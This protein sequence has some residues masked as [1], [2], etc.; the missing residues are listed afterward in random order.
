M[1]N[2]PTDTQAQPA[3]GMRD[4]L[5]IPNFSRLWTGQV[6][7]NFG[8]SLTN[9]TLLILVNELTGSTAAIALMAIVLGIP[10]VIF[11]TLAGVYVDRLN[12]QKNYGL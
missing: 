1:T 8:D 11:G 4:V 5:R 7:S 3:L 9:L 10:K 6:I 12:R 2:T